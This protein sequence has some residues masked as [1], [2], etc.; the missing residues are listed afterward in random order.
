MEWTSGQEWTEWTEWNNKNEELNL[1][2]KKKVKNK[3]SIFDEIQELCRKYGV[4]DITE[5]EV[6]NEEIKMIIKRRADLELWLETLDGK[7]NVKRD[8]VKDK[9]RPY[10]RYG[11]TRGRMVLLWRIGAL[12][13]RRHWREF[14]KSKGMSIDCPSNLC[15]IEDTLQHAAQCLFM[16]SKL[17]WNGDMETQDYYMAD[18]LV[19]LSYE[20][21]QRFREPLT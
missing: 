12:K 9:Y 7:L 5:K 10:H 17:R 13:F 15:G 19:N 18:F 1:K 16:G 2:R 14:Y 20:R 21:Y 8:S 3:K 6:D 11:K 4:P